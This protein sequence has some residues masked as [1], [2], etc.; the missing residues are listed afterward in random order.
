V[1][2][3]LKIIAILALLLILM[4]VRGAIDKS[5]EKG[6][7]QRSIENISLPKPRLKGPISLEETI[8][9]RRSIRNFASKPLNISQLAQICWAAQGITEEGGFKRA[10]PSAGALYPLELYLVIREES[11]EG[12]KAGVYRYRPRAHSLEI[13]SE[14][15]KRNRVARACLYQM[16]IAEAPLIMIIT[17]NYERTTWKYGERG[18]RYVHLEAGHAAQNVCLEAVALELGTVTIG[19]FRDKEVSKVLDL[20]ENLSPLYV[21]PIGYPKH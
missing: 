18:I 1:V 21:M 19:A 15:D 17:A 13:Y 9:E 10:A 3:K 6:A 11:I 8:K 20:P 2:I 16:F 5:I 4:V 14:G 12:L 7:L